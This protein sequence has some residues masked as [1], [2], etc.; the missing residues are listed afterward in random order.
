MQINKYNDL[1]NNY[2][3]YRRINPLESLY[4]I[5]K[6]YNRLRTE[7]YNKYSKAVKSKEKYK[8]SKG[9]EEDYKKILNEYSERLAEAQEKVY[10]DLD[11][12]IYKLNKGIREYK[13]EPP[14]P[15]QLRLL[16][17]LKLKSNVSQDELDGVAQ[18]VKE[19]PLALS[20]VVDIAKEKG[21][22][23]TRYQ[24]LNRTPTPSQLQA[25]VNS[26]NDT[27]L[28]YIESPLSRAGVLLEKRGKIHGEKSDALS[29]WTLYPLA[30]VD[31]SSKE[32]FYKSMYGMDVSEVNNLN[33][34]QS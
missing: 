29:V 19:N 13:L 24:E 4:E 6:E 34:L 23:H 22:L 17:T 7:L 30:Q 2:N 14:T 25:E 12:V 18:A 32:S 31:Y 33:T 3:P 21:Y 1:I 26:I 20:V 16:Q 8:G 5:M 9:Y 10:K 11:S 28:N 15:E 27:S